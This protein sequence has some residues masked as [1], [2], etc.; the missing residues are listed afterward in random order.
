MLK[1]HLSILKEFN[2]CGDKLDKKQAYCLIR[3]L[4]HMKKIETFPFEVKHKKNIFY[5][6]SLIRELI[7][8][9]KKKIKQLLEDNG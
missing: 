8:K 1:S 5:D 4:S 6:Y 3:Q 7:I 2:I 9:F